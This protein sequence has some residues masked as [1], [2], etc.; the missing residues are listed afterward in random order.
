MTMLFRPR[1]T[2]QPQGSLSVNWGNCLTRGLGSAYV[3]TSYLNLV[4]GAYA[5]VTGT[6]SVNVN[7]G[8]RALTNLTSSNFIDAPNVPKFVDGTGST[9]VLVL[10]PN[11]AFGSTQYVVY[12]TNESTGWYIAT[13]FGQLDYTIGGNRAQA[14]PNWSYN[15]PTCIAINNNLEVYQDGR[16]VTSSY[17]GFAGFGS[18]DLS[19]LRVGY[20]SWQAHDFT[21]QDLLARFNWPSRYITGAELLAIT[22]NPWQLVNNIPALSNRVLLPGLAYV[23]PWPLPIAQPPRS[24]STHLAM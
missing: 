23:D 5:S 19:S 20:S 24:F 6:P 16:Q 10:R 9:T 2:A 13:N 4:S 11:S 14:N 7:K 1:L 18:N 12:E 3:G 22:A 8:G 17:I 21:G 15:V